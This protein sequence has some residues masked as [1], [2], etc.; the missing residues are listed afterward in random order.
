CHVAI[1]ISNFGTDQETFQAA[2]RTAFEQAIRLRMPNATERP[3]VAH[4]IDL[5]VAA[6]PPAAAVL[7]TITG[8]VNL[9]LAARIVKVS[10]RLKRPWPDLSALALPGFAL[11]ILAAAIAGTMLPDL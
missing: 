4:L 10:G 8:V 11:A 5:L 6:I 2:L 9:W 3:D 7:A 1:A